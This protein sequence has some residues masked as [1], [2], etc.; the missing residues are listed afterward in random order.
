VR[1]IHCIAIEVIS[2]WAERYPRI[3]IAA[4]IAF[5]IVGKGMQAFT[6]YFDR[7]LK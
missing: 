2:Y 1:T 3:L 7:S 6:E 4:G 5:P